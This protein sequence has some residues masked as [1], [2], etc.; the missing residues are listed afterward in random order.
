MKRDAQRL[1]MA[2]DEAQVPT[3]ERVPGPDATGA[4]SVAQ[5]S[6]PDADWLSITT[7]D[8]A[9]YLKDS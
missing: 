2:D 9:L 1:G 5:E 8:P 7:G 6:E 4:A 3:A